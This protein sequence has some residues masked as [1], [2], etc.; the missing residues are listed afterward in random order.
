MAGHQVPNMDENTIRAG[1]LPV[2]RTST[3]IFFFGYKGPDPEV[4]FQQWFPSLFVDTELEESP[5][6][7]TS[8]H[9]M[10]YCKAI[11]F[12]DEVIAKQILAARTPGEAKTLGRQAGYAFFGFL[13]LSIKSLIF[14]N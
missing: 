5:G 1:E 13:I 9:Y 14:L 12:N 7:P 11:L 10:M 3:H 6:F 8:E 2:K 4:C